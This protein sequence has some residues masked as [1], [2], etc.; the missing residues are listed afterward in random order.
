MEQELLVDARRG[1]AAA[2]ERLVAPYRA[3]LGRNE[4]GPWF[5]RHDEYDD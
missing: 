4:A 2:F 5:R 1:D 3:P